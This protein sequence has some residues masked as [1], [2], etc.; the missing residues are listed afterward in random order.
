MDK[1]ATLYLYFFT[2]G[3]SDINTSAFALN[4][5]I[6]AYIMLPA[7]LLQILVSHLVEWRVLH[8]ARHSP[9]MPE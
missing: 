2:L 5:F 3:S 8:H 7:T 4:G 6:R 9:V 1:I